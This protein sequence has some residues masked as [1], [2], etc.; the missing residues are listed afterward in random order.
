MGGGKKREPDFR[1][2]SQPAGRPAWWCSRSPAAR[3]PCSIHVSA[4][5]C[6]RRTGR[7]P[8]RAWVR[9]TPAVPGRRKTTR[10]WPA[11]WPGCAGPCTGA[12][13]SSGPAKTLSLPPL[14][15]P[16][17]AILGSSHSHW[18]LPSGR[19]C[20]SQAQLSPAPAQTTTPERFPG[21]H[22]ILTSFNLNRWSMMKNH[23]FPKQC[24]FLLRGLRGQ[25]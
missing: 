11:G 1:A 20:P 13:H 3:E 18:A 14:P 10:P 4:C 16:V 22:S 19:L 8:P 5:T 12:G 21:K 17:P 2:V 6:Q 24:Y 23:P 7:S 15:T 9:T 25:F